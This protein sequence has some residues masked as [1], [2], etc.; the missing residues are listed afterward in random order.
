M[1]LRS[2]SQLQAPIVGK[3]CFFWLLKGRT[4][5]VHWALLHQ[6]KAII[7]N[8]SCC[9]CCRSCSCCCC[10]CCCCWRG[11]CNQHG[12]L[13]R[14]VASGRLRWS[15]RGP[16]SQS[17]LSWAQL[18]GRRWS[19]ADSSSGY[20]GSNKQPTNQP[21]YIYHILCTEPANQPTNQPTNQPANQPANQPTSQPASQP[22]NQLTNQ[23][24]SPKRN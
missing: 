11:T 17:H 2:G 9:I 16:A 10:C 1:V 7:Q 13:A 21:T 23:G 19:G 5:L 20:L 8:P 14:P 3:L 6:P 15:P 4:P 24:T 22:A 12:G 18:W